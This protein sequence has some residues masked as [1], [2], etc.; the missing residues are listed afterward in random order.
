MSLSPFFFSVY[1]VITFTLD[2]N[3]TYNL[4]SGSPVFWIG[5]GVALSVAFTTV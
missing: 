3:L 4:Y 5:V 1:A 2:G